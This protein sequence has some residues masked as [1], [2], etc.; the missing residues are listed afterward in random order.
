[1]DTKASSSGRMIDAARTFGDELRRRRSQA[2]LTQRELAEQVRYSRETVA[3]VESGR[4]YATRSLAV[5]SDEVLG[6]GGVLGRLWPWVERAQLAAD[7][8]RGPR[9]T[10]PATGWP[11]QDAAPAQDL[12]TELADWV[13]TIRPAID[14][15]PP[16]FVVRLRDLVNNLAP[17]R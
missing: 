8:R 16:E 2:G 5:R 4:R 10:P 13:A 11:A 17:A 7:R 6:T 15:A 3:A 1:M 9:P 14:Q 12:V